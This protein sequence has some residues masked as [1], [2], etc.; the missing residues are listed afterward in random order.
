MAETGTLRILLAGEGKTDVGDPRAEDSE[1]RE[2]VVQ[3]L[4]CHL[5]LPF[6]VVEIVPWKNIPKYRAGKCRDAEERN[7]LG[8][9][10]RASEMGCD[11]LVF[12]RDQDGDKGRSKSIEAALN[13]VAEEAPPVV[14]GTADQAIEAWVLAFLEDHRAEQ[15]TNPKSKLSAEHQSCAAKCEVIRRAKRFPEPKYA[16]SLNR[17]KERAVKVWNGASPPTPPALPEPS[18]SR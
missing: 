13:E 5:N 17:W 14:G 4:L 1:A 18:P 8:L 12:V 6:E 2:G 11:A 10:L 3:A 16:K 7:V 15:H 9:H